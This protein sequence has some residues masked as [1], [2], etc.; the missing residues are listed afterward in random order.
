MQVQSPTL[1]H[2]TEAFLLLPLSPPRCL[3]ILPLILS[4]SLSDTTSADTVEANFEPPVLHS[5]YLRTRTTSFCPK[6]KLQI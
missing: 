4:I 3:C 6:S 2:E 5:F 1:H